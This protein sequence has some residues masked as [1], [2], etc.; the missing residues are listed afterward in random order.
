MTQSREEQ[1]RNELAAE[2]ARLGELEEQRARA[3]SRVEALR[4]QLRQLPRVRAEAP[5]G[6][7]ATHEPEPFTSA[8]KLALFRRRFRGREDLFAKRWE[9]AK[10]GRSGYAPACSNESWRATQ[11]PAD[12]GRG[13]SDGFAA[14]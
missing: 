3:V 8:E 12:L 11:C 7:P 2:E 1:L 10:S 6:A 9:N 4:Q 14:K 5:S 13:N